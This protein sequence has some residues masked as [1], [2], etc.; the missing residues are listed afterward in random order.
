MIDEYRILKD[1]E[2]SGRDLFEVLPQHLP[3]G[4]GKQ[5][6]MSVRTAGVLTKI[7]SEHLRHTSLER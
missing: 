5:W 3:A 6:E 4:T 1:L 7:L 2:G